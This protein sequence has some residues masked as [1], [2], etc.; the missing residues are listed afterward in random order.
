MLHLVY[1][2]LLTKWHSELELCIGELR[3]IGEHGLL[4][5]VGVHQVHQ[6]QDLGHVQPLVDE[7]HGLGGVLHRLGEPENI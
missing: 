6:H 1:V 2:C 3:D 5:H 7:V 4:V